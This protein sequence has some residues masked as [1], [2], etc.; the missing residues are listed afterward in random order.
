LQ[1]TFSALFRKKLKDGEAGFLQGCAIVNDQLASSSS[2]AASLPKTVS[3]ADDIAEVFG[4]KQMAELRF[5]ADKKSKAQIEEAL[6]G[7]IHSSEIT[8]AVR[9]LVATTAEKLAK[10]QRQ[11]NN[12]QKLVQSR[13]SNK[14]VTR[15]F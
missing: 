15:Q 11:R 10:T 9:A 1:L 3:S 7:V 4:E 2:A 14:E 12:D 8:D 6:L 13:V 5:N